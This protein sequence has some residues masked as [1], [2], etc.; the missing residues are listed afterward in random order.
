MRVTAHG[1]VAALPHGEIKRQR[2]VLFR[3]RRFAPEN[4]AAMIIEI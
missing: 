4:M 1:L 2:A 3:G